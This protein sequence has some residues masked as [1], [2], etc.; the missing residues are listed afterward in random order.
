MSVNFYRFGSGAR[1]PLVLDPA[2]L[3]IDGELISTTVYFDYTNNWVT[4]NNPGAQAALPVQVLQVST[5]GNKTVSYNSGTGNANWI[6]N[7]NVALCL[8]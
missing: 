7:Q 3:T 6:Y 1:I 4:V 8:I 5:S 2:S